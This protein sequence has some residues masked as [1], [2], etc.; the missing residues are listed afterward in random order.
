MPWAC[1]ECSYRTRA[2]DDAARHELR[3]LEDGHEMRLA[4]C[5]FHDPATLCYCGCH[6]DILEP[7]GD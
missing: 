2:L 3:C 7:E 6:R 4:A 5:C 1:T